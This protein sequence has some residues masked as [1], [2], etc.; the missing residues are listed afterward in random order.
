MI[1]IVGKDQLE[2]FIWENSNEK[3]IIV[4]YFGADWCGPCQNLKKK[5]DSDDVKLQMSDLI[6][7]HLDIDDEKNEEVS[8]IY[9]VKSLP[10]QIFVTLKGT[11]I[12][13]LKRVV[14]FDWNGFSS[15]YNTIK[16]Q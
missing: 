8:E 7:G 14:G 6:I 12:V 4:I 5:L 10:T 3:K 11:Q 15:A 16:Q 13:E 1:D 9:Q 2:E